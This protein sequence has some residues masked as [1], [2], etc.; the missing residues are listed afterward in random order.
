[1]AIEKTKRHKSS[2]ID[3]IPAEL[4]KV[5]CRTVRSEIFVLINSIWNKEEFPEERKASITVP[6]YKKGGDNTGCSNTVCVY[7]L[8]NLIY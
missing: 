2:G 8:H 5:G 1:M 4:V 6:I 3:Q 7:S